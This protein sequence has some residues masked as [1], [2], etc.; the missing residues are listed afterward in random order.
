MRYGGT[1]SRKCFDQCFIC[2]RI[3]HKSKDCWYLKYDNADRHSKD[4]YSKEKFQ[5]LNKFNNEYINNL[6][7][8]NKT[9]LLEK[10]SKNEVSSNNSNICILTEYWIEVLRVKQIV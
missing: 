10:E 5:T 7:E 4:Y 6:S 3:N 8:R 2:G 1:G 9:T